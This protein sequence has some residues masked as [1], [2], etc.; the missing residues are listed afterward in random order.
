[1]HCG[2]GN[3]FWYRHLATLL[4]HERPVLGLLPSG[5]DGKSEFHKSVD[6]MA[7]CYVQRMQEVFPRGPYMV[8]GY[9]FGGSIA[10]EVA[11][12]LREM[13]CE[14]VFAGLFDACVYGTLTLTHSLPE[15]RLRLAKLGMAGKAAHI[16]RSIFGNLRT[17]YFRS[18]RAVKRLRSWVPARVCL[19][20]GRPIPV[21]HRSNY[22]RGIFGRAMLDYVPKPYHG[23]VTIYKQTESN[24]E[25]R[26][27]PDLGWAQFVPKEQLKLVEI[28][29]QHGEMLDPPVVEELA[30]HLRL[31]IKA[32]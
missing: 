28:A 5:V 15:H 20:L 2:G 23:T 3:L 11:R 1:M 12:Q 29:G 26:D 30:A 4:G 19:A 7:R 16:G 8:C 14:V 10:Y 32:Y 21:E 27:H 24:W 13:G 9:S 18:S 22:L 17:V 31:S 25:Y 6:E